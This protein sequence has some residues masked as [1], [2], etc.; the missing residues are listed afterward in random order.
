[1]KMLDR[2]MPPHPKDVAISFAKTI[3]NSNIYLMAQPQKMELAKANWGT[4][5]QC[6]LIPIHLGLLFILFNMIKNMK[7]RPTY[8]KKKEPKTYWEITKANSRV[9]SLFLKTSTPLILKIDYLIVYASVNLGVNAIFYKETV[10]KSISDFVLLDFNRSIFGLIIGITLMNI[11]ASFSDAFENEKFTLEDIKKSIKNY[12]KVSL[13]MMII[14]L[15]LCSIF[16]YEFRSMQDNWFWGSL[17]GFCKTFSYRF[18]MPHLTI[19]AKKIL[20]GD[21]KDIVDFK[22]PEDEKKKTV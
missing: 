5:I 13:I 11:N 2:I 18:F 9:I 6:T 3:P 15:Y 22:E 1:M 8:I 19:Y 21:R 16:C 14:S 7:K 12:L 20:L 4:F 10:I 17:I